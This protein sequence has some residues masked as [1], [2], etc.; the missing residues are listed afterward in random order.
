MNRSDQS[1]DR[2]SDS[3]IPF[4]TILVGGI[5]FQA[6]SLDSATEWL[7]MQAQRRCGVSVRLANAYCVALADSD[8]RYKELLKR[9][10]VNFADGTPV[11]WAM[12]VGHRK[13]TSNSQEP[14]R[15]RGPSFFVQNLSASQSTQTSNFFLG[16]TESTLENLIDEGKKRFPNLQ[17][18][19]SYAPPFAP[20][21]DRFIDE[22]TMRIR[23]SNPDIVWVGLGTPKQ[24]FVTT[25]LAEILDVPCVGV[26]AAFDFLAGS[27]QEAPLWIQNS[28]LEWAYRFLQEPRRLW[29]R[30]VFGN[31]R[32]L[33]AALRPSNSPRTR[34]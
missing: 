8:Q 18:A 33:V 27:V 15:V 23:E 14:R 31:V 13:L 2:N 10:G 34:R 30:Y 32:F 3:E 26:G 25:R 12:R 4:Q 9:D 6:A 20:I 28:G 19:G 5:P 16:S 17:V 22:C 1:D 29:R 11:V 21:T 7:Q 24:D